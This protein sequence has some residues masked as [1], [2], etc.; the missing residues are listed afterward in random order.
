M[1]VSLCAMTPEDWEAVAR[2]YADGIATGL[3]TFETEVPEWPAWNAAHPI[4]GD[5]REPVLAYRTPLEWLQGDCNGF[6][7]LDEDW[8]LAETT[9]VPSIQPVNGDV[10]FGRKLKNLVLQQ[11]RLPKIVIPKAKT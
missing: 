11:A 4:R 3:A 7:L 5:R 10:A 8:L 2:I 9:G 6:C 1:S